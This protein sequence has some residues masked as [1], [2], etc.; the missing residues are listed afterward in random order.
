MH[1]EQLKQKL[2]ENSDDVQALRQA[3]RTLREHT[4]IKW[5]LRELP[6]YLLPD[7]SYVKPLT[8]NTNVDVIAK[9]KRK[10][11]YEDY[12]NAVQRPKRTLRDKLVYKDSLTEDASPEDLVPLSGRKIWKMKHHKSTKR[13][14][15]TTGKPPRVAHKLWKSAKK[16]T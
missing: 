11:R 10:R 6:E 3:M 13:N 4:K 15:D 7:L 8:G 16:F 5:H 12:Q 9:L 14:G 2:S 1:N